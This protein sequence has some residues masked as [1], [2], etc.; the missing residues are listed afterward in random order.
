[1]YNCYAGG[2]GV[3]YPFSLYDT[4][5]DTEFLKHGNVAVELQ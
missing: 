2:G 4:A 3:A 5:F 1:M